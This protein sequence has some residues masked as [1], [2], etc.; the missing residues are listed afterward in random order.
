MRNRFFSSGSTNAPQQ[1]GKGAGEPG[2]WANGGYLQLEK[3]CASIPFPLT[4]IL[5]FEEESDPGVLVYIAVS[6]GERCGVSQHVCYTAC[7]LF[8]ND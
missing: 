4:A 2:L 6:G 3:R 8:A 7:F 5:N 1:H